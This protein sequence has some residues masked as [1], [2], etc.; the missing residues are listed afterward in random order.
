MSEPASTFP[1]WL[2]SPD[3]RRTHLGPACSIG[4][5][6]GNDIVVDGER[7]SRRHAMISLRDQDDFWV[8]D[9]GSS[10]GTFLNERRIVQPV[11]L[12]DGDRIGVGNCDFTFRQEG[13]PVSRDP[14]AA[15]RET[16]REVQ[17]ISCWLLVADMAG[18]TQFVTRSTA[19]LFAER[20]Q[21]WLTQSREIVER[22]RGSINKFLGDGFLAY[23]R[24]AA[25]I[26]PMVGR[27]VTELQGLSPPGLPQIRL[28]IHWGTVVAGGSATLG[29]E[30]LLG[31]EVHFA[32]RLEKVAA[33]LGRTSIVSN[34]AARL[35]GSQLRLEP[36][37]VHPVPGFDGE[38]RCHTIALG[39][40]F[41]N[42]NHDL[43]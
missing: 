30:S 18:S 21:A 12:S 19:E 31:P 32:F 39:N 8:M 22:H 4:R 37:G 14:S 43:E 17:S 29:E 38:H 34:A 36:I 9:L 15:D 41:R 2:E 13:S 1:A 35:L 20:T 42:P 26:P 7:V 33:T 23:W 5:V 28:A 16:L 10:N 6:A 27:A 25:D 3:G 24:D 40:P 11:K